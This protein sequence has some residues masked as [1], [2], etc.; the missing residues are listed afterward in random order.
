MSADEGVQSVD[1]ADA[2]L[3]KLV[4]VVAGDGVDGLTVDVYFLIGNDG[5]AAVFGAPHTVENSAEDV[6]AYGKL[7]GLAQKARFRGGYFQSRGAFKE[8][9][10]GFVAVDLQYFSASFFAVFLLD[11]DEFVIFDAFDVFDEH[12]RSYD[13]TYG[14]VFFQHLF[15][16]TRSKR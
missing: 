7:D 2:R 8:L 13:L 4:R 12:Q 5:S 10:K 6:G 16:L 1:G 15:L 11:L 14:F 9:D 3:D